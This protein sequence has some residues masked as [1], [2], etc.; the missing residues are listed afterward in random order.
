MTNTDHSVDTDRSPFP[1]SSLW[2][3]DDSKHHYQSNQLSWNQAEVDLCRPKDSSYVPSHTI[4]YYAY[5]NCQPGSYGSHFK[6]ETGWW[7]GNYDHGAAVG[8]QEADQLA[9]GGYGAGYY[10]AMADFQGGG[11]SEATEVDT[12]TP[13]TNL[14]SMTMDHASC[15]AS[16]PWM[17]P[18]LY[19]PHGDPASYGAQW[20]KEEAEDHDVIQQVTGPTAVSAPLIYQVCLR[21]LLS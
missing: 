18:N 10:P 19:Q 8:Y 3:P 9:W 4:S 20:V 15:T 14:A 6:P 5:G 11:Y 12:T 2:L 17:M 21:P 1:N 16:S 13:W 7:Y